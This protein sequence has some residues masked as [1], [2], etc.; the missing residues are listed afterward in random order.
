MGSSFGEPATRTRSAPWTPTPREFGR[1]AELFARPPGL[2]HGQVFKPLQGA[3]S[4]IDAVLGN[5][6]FW[7]VSQTDIRSRR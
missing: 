5:V 1:A 7:G 2:I 4:A 3:H 6:S